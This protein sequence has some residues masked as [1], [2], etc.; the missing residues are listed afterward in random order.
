[1]ADVYGVLLRERGR[2]QVKVIKAIRTH[3][4][5]GLIAAKQLFDA[6]GHVASGLSADAAEQFVRDLAL[7]GAVAEVVSPDAGALLRSLESLRAAGTITVEEF[8]AIR[9]RIPANP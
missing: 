3:T 7:A 5:L 8:E 2:S 4:G 9:R 6:A 1:M